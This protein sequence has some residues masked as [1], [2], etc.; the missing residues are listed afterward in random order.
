MRWDPSSGWGCRWS[1]YFVALIPFHFC[2]MAENLMLAIGSASPFPANGGRLSFRLQSGVIPGV[3]R[4]PL[5]LFPQLL[6]YPTL[7][8]INSSIFSICVFR[9]CNCELLQICS[10]TT[11]IPMTGVSMAD[12]YAIYQCKLNSVS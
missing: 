9:A 12:R 5:V 11:S 7:K 6:P 10:G 4:N 2:W 8:E 3:R 1:L